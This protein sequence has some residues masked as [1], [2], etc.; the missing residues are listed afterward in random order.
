MSEKKMKSSEGLRNLYGKE[1]VEKF[2]KTQSPKRLKRLIKYFQVKPHFDVID[3]ACGNGL[4]LSHVAP[5]VNKYVGIDFS[6]VFIRDAIKRKEHMGISNA[7]FY[8]EDILIFCK[9]HPRAFDCGFAMD[10]SEHVFDEEWVELLS[11]MRKS[12]KPG[13]RL[14]L[15]TPNLEFFLELMKDKNIIFKQF[16]EHVAVR[17]PEANINLLKQAGFQIKTVSLLPHYNIIKIVH[18]LSFIPFV[19]RYF[20]A[21]IFI[22]AIA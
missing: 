8:C 5:Q 4:L 21:R 18:I 9:K 10:F 6:E 12:L 2:A 17:T 7:E 1:Y 20:K 14:Y 15:H 13:G 11:S 16:E 3:F 22:E 19:G